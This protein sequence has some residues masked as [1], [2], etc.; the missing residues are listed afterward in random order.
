MSIIVDLTLHVTAR[1]HHDSPRYSADPEAASANTLAAQTRRVLLIWSQSCD[2]SLLEAVEHEY[3]RQTG[4]VV[5]A[6][7][8]RRPILMSTLLFIQRFGTGAGGAAERG[9]LGVHSSQQAVGSGFQELGL[10]N[11]T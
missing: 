4:S 9:D 1:R 11:G 3:P 7:R 8:I 2:A 6:A 5:A 10:T